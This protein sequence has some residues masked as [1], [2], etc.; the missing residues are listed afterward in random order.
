MFEYLVAPCKGESA[1]AKAIN[2]KGKEGWE[3]W[4]LSFAGTDIVESRMSVD[5]LIKGA[6]HPQMITKYVL[7]LR[8][9]VKTGPEA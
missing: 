9:R 1:I 7:I 6:A 5:D 8:R 2:D 4:I 3:P